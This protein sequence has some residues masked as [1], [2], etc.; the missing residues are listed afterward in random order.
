[1]RFFCVGKLETES[2]SDRV[3]GG[4]NASDQQ[5]MLVSVY[6][7]VNIKID[8]MWI[9]ICIMSVYMVRR[10]GFLLLP[11]HCWKV[12]SS[13]FSKH[14]QGWQVSSSSN[15]LHRDPAC[16]ISMMHLSYFS[17]C[18]WTSF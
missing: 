1:M 2:Q 9:I 14:R 18:L 16:I 3:E 8:T 17:S 11:H 6:I 12:R 15:T 13:A 5:E 7:L 10:H 4:C